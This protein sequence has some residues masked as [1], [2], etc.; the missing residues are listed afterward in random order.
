MTKSTAQVDGR[1]G[2]DV[3]RGAS[4][5]ITRTRL[6]DAAASL[7]A[8]R[9]WSAV[10]TRAIAERA[11]VNHALVHYHF[12]SV[13]ALLREAVLAR[14]E[15]E[16]TAL[17][18]ELLDDRPFPEGLVSTMQLLDEFDLRSETGVLVA[19]LLL[20]STRDPA[21]A[22]AMGGELRSWR[23]LLE[24]RLRTAQ[25]RGS[26]RSDV[27]PA[28]LALLIAAALDGLWLQRMAV[29]DAGLAD[30]AATLTRLLAPPTPTP[31]SEEEV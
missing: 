22:E 11:G 25:E 10:T 12:G 7:V 30:A 5:E 29:P 26:I 19:E 16:L 27:S 24:P 8:E 13:A 6:L 9:G 15:P 20:R 17:L 31:T 18:T 4:G 1:T 21:V 28:S 14:I 2:S 23:S 3:T